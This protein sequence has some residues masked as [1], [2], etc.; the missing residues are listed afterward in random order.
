MGRMSSVGVRKIAARR[1]LLA[2]GGLGAVL[3]LGR[4]ARVVEAAH[5]AEDLG[6]GL[7]NPT[8]GGVITTTTRI[9]TGT[10]GDAFS[11]IQAD[12]SA[13]DAVNG[14]GGLQTGSTAGGRGVF[15]E[16]G[17]NTGTGDGGAGINATGGNLGGAPAAGRTAGAGI[18]AIGGIA[19]PIGAGGDGVRAFGGSSSV[20]PGAGVRAEGGGNAASALAMGAA[21][22]LGLGGLGGNAVTRT[23]VGVLGQSTSAE[24]V[25]GESAFGPGAL[26]VSVNYAGMYAQSTNHWG[27]YAQAPGFAGVFQGSVYIAGG[28]TLVGGFLTAVKHPDRSSRAA[29]GVTSAEPLLEDV[30]RARLTAGAAHVDL[31]PAF[32]ALI[33]SAGY[34]VFPLPYGDCKGLYVTIRTASGFDVRELHSGTSSLDFGYRVVA[35][36][37][38][39]DRTRLAKLDHLEALPAVTRTEIPEATPCSNGL[40]APAN[41]TRQDAAPPSRP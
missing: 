12:G 6:L 19:G 13:G 23:G 14:Y 26:G 11:V 20:A 37:R 1:K 4:E 21:G 24:G 16:G 38:D 2:V 29:H 17:R 32:A 8:A 39:G 41:G 25:R 30:G 33:Q 27:L 31:D 15:A 22:V 3:G 5:Q 36:R 28:L 7:T 34:D 40:T 9:N 35:S 10:G 18:S